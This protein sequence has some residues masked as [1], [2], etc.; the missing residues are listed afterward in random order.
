MLDFAVDAGARSTDAADVELQHLSRRC[1]VE[2]ADSCA[3]RAS[4]AD[5]CDRR[6]DGV[7]VADAADD[8]DCGGG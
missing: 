4:A 1:K 2:V 8:D 7:V 5:C 6:R 3:I